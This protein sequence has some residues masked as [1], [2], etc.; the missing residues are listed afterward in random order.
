MTNWWAKWT[1]CLQWFHYL[2]I[3]L[4]N[5]SVFILIL[6]DLRSPSQLKGY[7]PC[8]ILAGNKY[9]L[10]TLGINDIRSFS[11]G[12]ALAPTE[13]KTYKFPARA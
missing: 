9:Q 12:E 2:S 11:K 4:L 3:T 6:N 1:V 7:T 5:I 10:P 13:H 8:L